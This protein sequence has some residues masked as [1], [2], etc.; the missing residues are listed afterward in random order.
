MSLALLCS[1]LVATTALAAPTVIRVTPGD[2]ISVLAEGAKAEVRTV[3]RHVGGLTK[4]D[5]EFIADELDLVREDV[6]VSMD[7]R[8][9][10]AAA[11]V[12]RKIAAVA[13]WTTWDPL[14]WLLA[15]AALIFMAW[16]MSWVTGRAMRRDDAPTQPVNVTNNITCPRWPETV[17]Q[18]KP[19]EIVIRGPATPGI[20]LYGTIEHQ[21]T[22]HV[23]QIDIT[24]LVQHEVGGE[25]RF[26][27]KV[28]VETKPSDPQQS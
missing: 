7:D 10:T 28:L 11:E 13:P 2:S 20:V 12:D 24:E 16:L 8:F 4:A 26:A 17:G 23:E 9:K 21:N 18:E 27:G 22:H 3:T 15:I 19:G 14:Q 5:R 6:N 1:F 25:A